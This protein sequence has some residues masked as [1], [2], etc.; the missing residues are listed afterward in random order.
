LTSAGETA[1]SYLTLK[2]GSSNQQL[3]S[4]AETGTS[5]F[6]ANIKSTASVYGKTTYFPF[7][8]TGRQTAGAKSF[9]ISWPGRK[10]AT[11]PIQD[12]VF[13]VPSATEIS[14]TVINATVAVR[15]GINGGTYSIQIAAP[16]AQMGTLGP[17]VI[18]A[19][20]NMVTLPGLKEGYALWQG[21]VDLGK[22]PTGLVSISVMREGATIDT[23]MVNPGAAGW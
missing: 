19:T 15:S 21:S 18:R 10:A 8:I 17:K 9:T 4:E 12:D 23:F 22:V 2:A 14:G 11:F 5:V 3:I 13:V 16:T 6:G 20:L 1:P 7:I